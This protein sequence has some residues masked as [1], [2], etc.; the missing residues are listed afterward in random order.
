MHNTGRA[1]LRAT[2]GLGGLFGGLSGV[3]GR[4][5]PRGRSPQRHRPKMAAAASAPALSAR[6]P[7]R[8]VAAGGGGGDWGPAEGLP[9]AAAPKGPDIGTGTQT[10]TH[11]GTGTAL[12]RRLGP[13]GAAAGLALPPGVHLQGGPGPRGE[14]EPAPSPPPGSP[15]VTGQGGAEIASRLLPLNALNRENRVSSPWVPCRQQVW[16]A[17]TLIFFN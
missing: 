7:Q 2:K 15:V 16:V 17:G 5:P 4:L 13:R 8:H 12:H 14:Q 11:T 10:G 6:L 1:P 3:R 9:G